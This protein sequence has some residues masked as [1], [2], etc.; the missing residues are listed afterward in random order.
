MLKRLV[1]SGVVLALLSGTVLAQESPRCLPHERFQMILQE[2]YGET[3][4]VI[5]L[6]DDKRIMEIWGN[7][8]AGSWTATMT[9]P[10]GMT[11][12]AATG[13]SF[14]PTAMPKIEVPV[15]PKGDPA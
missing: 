7:L 2:K 11:C 8:E 10:D 5:G 9:T 12:F 14:D 15:V 3:R 4:Y 6:S 1:L 13:S